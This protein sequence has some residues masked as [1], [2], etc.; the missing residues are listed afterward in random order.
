[1]LK[2]DFLIQN[3][4]IATEDIAQCRLLMEVNSSS[5]SYVLMSVRGMRPLV[6]KY[7]Q[8]DPS[9]PGLA[10]EIVQEIL[11]EDD[12][13]ASPAVNEIFLVYNFPESNLVP[14]PFF[15]TD[16]IKPFTDLIYGNLNKELILNEKIPW[17]ELHNVYRVPAAIHRLLQ[18]K[19]TEGKHWHFYSLQLKCHKM[20]HDKEEA[21]YLRVFFY[22]DKMIV[23]VLKNGQLQLAQTFSYQDAKDIAYHL[24]NCCHQLNLDQETLILEISGL[25][26]KQSALYEELQKYFLNINFE[27]LEDSIKITDELRAYPLH[28]FSSLLK[29]AVC[30]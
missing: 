4:H 18:Q 3:E 11:D 28:Y 25:I 9:K 5:F 1:M 29:M 24:L 10:A 20:F 26:E 17:W 7:F 15:N 23:L 14:E 13:L 19:F 21:Q 2:P 22:A 30:V 27:E 16:T 6:I 8:W 12:Y